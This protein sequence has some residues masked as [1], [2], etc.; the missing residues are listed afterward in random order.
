MS[1][2]GNAAGPVEAVSLSRIRVARLASGIGAVALT[3]AIVSWLLA[4]DV[5][6][7]TLVS[8]VIALLGIGAWMLLA[9]DDFRALI[10]GRQAVYGT[11]SLLVSALFAGIVAIVYSLAVSTGIAV[12]LTSAGYYSLKGDVQPV[13]QNLERPI[14][15]TAFYNRLLLGAQSQDAPILRMFVDANPAMVRLV[16]VDP[17]EQPVLARRFGLQSS[18]GVFVSYLNDDG[19]PDLRSTGTVQVRGNAPNE[20]LVAEAILQLQ[21]RGQ[22][23][24]AFTTGSGELSLDEDA[25]GIRDGL[26]NVGIDVASLDPN[27][28]DIPA[29]ATA[30]VV[31]GPRLDFGAEAVGR[32]ARYMAGG[33]KLLLMAEPAYEGSITFMTTED[34]PLTRYLEDNWGITPQRDIL[35]DPVAYYISQYYVRAAQ[36]AEGHPVVS[37]DETG[38]AAQPLFMISQS[39]AVSSVPNVQASV[40]YATSP[41]AFGKL[42]LREVAANPDRAV[43]EPGDLTGPLSLVVAAENTASGARLIVVGDADWVRNDSITSFDG[44]FLWTNMIDWL[45]QFIERVT[46]N[47]VSM[48]LP[49]NVSSA[50]LN[51]AA[52]ITMLALPAAVLLAG[53]VVWGRRVRR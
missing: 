19:A 28:E 37:K 33:G 43:A 7:L 48:I 21:A 25:T 9:P 15:I 12:D 35:F 31:L 38:T 4:G 6:A 11:N 20:R 17:D 52:L 41:Q 13:V 26:L 23:K 51:A 40:L 34:S 1:A 18:Y 32:I 47:P 49:L 3:V 27:E 5:T 10:T 39:W 22:F 45:T 2:P 30:L 42:D 53:A 36:Y 44:Q 46:I 50:D 29:D 24:V 14:Q 16:Y 8:A